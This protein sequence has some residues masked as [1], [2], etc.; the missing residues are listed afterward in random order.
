VLG[1][2]FAL[3]CVCARPGAP[4]RLPF[5]LSVSCTSERRG[6]E[7][8]RGKIGRRERKRCAIGKAPARQGRQEQGGAFP[9]PRTHAISPRERP[10]PASVWL[11]CVCLAFVWV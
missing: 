1:A 8:M 9:L 11:A 2:R 5:I 7:R 3:A 6:A 4:E 10:L